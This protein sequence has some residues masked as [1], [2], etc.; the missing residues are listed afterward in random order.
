MNKNIIFAI[1]VFA[2][3]YAYTTSSAQF[4]PASQFEERMFINNCAGVNTYTIGND[5]VSFNNP[6]INS[7]DLVEVSV[8]E[9]KDAWHLGS[10]CDFSG[11][12]S[13]INRQVMPSIRFSYASPDVAYFDPD[14]CLI[15]SANREL[16]A[17]AVYYAY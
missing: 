12:T 16:F 5:V 1:S 11:F 6:I 15:E 13:R 17:V 7:T 4:I 14:V 9:Q 8:Y 3:L 2:I 10:A